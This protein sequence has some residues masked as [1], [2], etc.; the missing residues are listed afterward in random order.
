MID[1]KSFW[2]DVDNEVENVQMPEEY[3]NI[4]KHILCRDC[5]QVGK[6]LLNFKLKH[7]K[8]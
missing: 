8:F 2:A 7:S 5:H 4:V 3:R 6:C 1:M